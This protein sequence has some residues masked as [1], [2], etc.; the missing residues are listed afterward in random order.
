V[1]TIDDA[2]AVMQAIDQALPQPDGLKWF[3]FLYLAVTEAVRDAIASGTV[4]SDAAWVTHL[5]VTFA[6]LYFA[7]VS[8]A[9]G[10]PAPMPRA[11]EPLF[12]SRFDSHIARVQYAVA[13]MNAHINRDLALALVGTH[14]DRN[15]TPDRT[16][17]HFQDFKHVDDLLVAVEAQVKPILLTGVLLALDG[18][19][20][21]LDDVLAM[22]KVTRAREGAWTNS[23]VLWSIRPLP[24]LSASF[25]ESMD[26]IT[27]FAGRGLLL[28]TQL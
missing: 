5:D 10:G 6:N 13:G 4:Y 23:E 14:V 28:P 2:I 7:A 27:G 16:S 18:T 21:Q 11:W 22:W 9:V 19:L 20:G 12:D 26:R 3:N 8:T 25:I 17:V 15:T 24:L 1:T